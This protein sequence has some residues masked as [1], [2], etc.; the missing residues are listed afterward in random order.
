MAGLLAFNQQRKQDSRE[1]LLNAAVKLFSRDGY[2]AVTIEDVTAAAGVSR[3]T[4]YRHFAGKSAVALELFRRASLEGGPRLLSVARIDYRDRAALVSWLTDFF[5]ADRDMRGILR[6]LSQANVEEADFSQQVQ[7]FIVNL[8]AKLGE[9]IA[10]RCRGSP[11]PPWARRSQPSRS[12]PS[13]PGTRC[14][15]SRLGC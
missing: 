2:G 4:F 13:S 8:I 9:T 12:I 3:I 15:G 1:K 10:R 5:A 7:P 6:V 11:S 14:A